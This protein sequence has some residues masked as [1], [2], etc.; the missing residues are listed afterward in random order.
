MCLT[1]QA[2]QARVLRLALLIRCASPAH[3]SA[4][5]GS[6]ADCRRIQKARAAAPNES[7]EIVEG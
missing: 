7:T 5:A 6:R 4:P 1:R 2:D 3:R